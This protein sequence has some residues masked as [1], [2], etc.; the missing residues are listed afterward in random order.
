[1]FL[2]NMDRGFRKIIEEIE[3]WKREDEYVFWK[4]GFIV[5]FGKS[6]FGDRERRW[7]N[8]VGV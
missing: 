1:M 4:D 3:V 8:V 6:K 5:R 7:E 2:K